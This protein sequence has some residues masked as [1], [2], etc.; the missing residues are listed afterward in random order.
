MQPYEDALHRVNLGL[1]GQTCPSLNGA[2]LGIPA[3]TIFLVVN[4]VARGYP[5]WDALMRLHDNIPFSAPYIGTDP[6]WLKTLIFGGNKPPSQKDIKNYFTDVPSVDFIAQGPAW[7]ESSRLVYFE[8]GPLGI[9]DFVNGSP[10]IYGV[11]S[12]TTRIAYKLAE[13][14][15]HKISREEFESYPMEILQNPVR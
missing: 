10:I 11:S 8:R 13:H 4:G 6:D 14:K 3:G 12:Q 1:T 5:S 15:A 2:L 9:Y 7:S